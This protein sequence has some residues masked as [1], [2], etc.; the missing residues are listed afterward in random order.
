MFF[1]SMHPIWQKLLQ[2]QKRLLIEIEEKV[3]S[4]SEQ[5]TPPL[6]K[7]MRAFQ[8]DPDSIK[9][10]IIGQDPYPTKGAAVGLAFAVGANQPLPASLRNLMAELKTD[11]NQNVTCDGDLEKWVEQGVM[12][13]NSSLTTVVGLSEAHKHLGWDRFTTAAVRA[14]DDYRDG[15]LVCLSLGLS[16]RKLSKEIFKGVVVEATHPSPL[17][18]NRGFFGSKIYSRVNSSLKDLGV[19]PIDWSC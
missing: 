4:A 7:V 8:R 13:L 16:A 10:L 15:K 19:E 9:L 3:L 18:A 17:S 6:E 5:I 12:L 11:I 2:P 1:E 14:L